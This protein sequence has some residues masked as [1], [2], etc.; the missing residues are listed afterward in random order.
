MFSCGSHSTTATEGLWGGEHQNPSLFIC[1]ELLRWS[2]GA[3]GP[4]PG[5]MGIKL[6][7]SL[8]GLQGSGVV[9]RS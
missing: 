7:V 8:R 4:Q 6:C 9:P 3:D 5:G 2:V 1:E